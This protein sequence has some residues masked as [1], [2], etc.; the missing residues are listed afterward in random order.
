MN[1]LA[2]LLTAGND[3]TLRYGVLLGDHVRGRRALAVWPPAVRRGVRLH[4]AVDT[5]T[6]RHPATANART[7]LPPPFRRYANIMLDIYFDHL[8]SR[9][10]TRF[11]STELHIFAQQAL[12]LMAAHRH[13][14]PA[15]LRRFEDYARSTR[16]LERYRQ[17]HALHQALTGVGTRLRRANPLHQAMPVLQARDGA[18]EA[19]FL[20]LFP[21]VLDYSAAWLDRA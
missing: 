4:R 14:S 18:L 15:S 8:L 21:D 6:D 9:H 16:I 7:L 2:H 17:P 5:F 3:S 11:A 1:Y 19:A 13:V 12:A 20:Q 10:W